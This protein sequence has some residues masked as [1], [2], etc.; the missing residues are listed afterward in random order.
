MWC[1]LGSNSSQ[2]QAVGSI[3]AVLVAIALGFVALRQARAAD[4]QA[5]AAKIQAGA[6]RAQVESANRQIETSLIIG[7]NQTS[8]NISITNDSDLGGMTFRDHL[9]ILNNGFG[10]AYKL[11]L[12]YRDQS[13]GNAISLKHD[14]LVI[15]DSMDVQFDLSRGVTSGFRL[16]YRT[17]FDTE[18]ALEFELHPTQLVPINQQVRLVSR[19]YPVSTLIK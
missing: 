6:A 19:G 10:T 12:Q 17:M 18:Y 4:A 5:I 13:A 8:P 1:W 15:K 9:S 7:D 11:S 2:L 16:T 3:A 14:R